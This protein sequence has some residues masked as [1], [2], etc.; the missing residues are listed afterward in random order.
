MFSS[1][2]TRKQAIHKKLNIN[3]VSNKPTLFNIHNHS[4]YIKS[5]VYSY[6]FILLTQFN[7]NISFQFILESNGMYSRNSFD[8]R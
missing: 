6:L 7:C 4:T 2:Y 5:I 3:S 1:Y 8:Y